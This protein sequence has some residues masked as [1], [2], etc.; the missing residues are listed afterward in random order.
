M[1]AYITDVS[2]FL[3]G[4]P[5]ANN[6]LDLYLGSVDRISARTR[7][8]ILAGNGIE[9]RHYAVE[10]ATGALTHTNAQLAAE[11]VGR[12]TERHEKVAEKIQ[13][14]CC[15]TSSPDQLMPGHAAMVQGELGIGPCEIVSTAGVCV[16]GITA[17]KY[18]AMS[19]A[20]GQTDNAV[21]TGSELASTFIRTDFF[22]AMGGGAKRL[23]QGENH[24]A[25][26]FEEQF[27]RWM[28]SDGAGAVLIKREPA[29]DR[30]SLRIDG[31]EILSHAHRLEACMY[32]GAVKQEDG[33]LK[34]WR[35]YARSGAAAKEGVFTI[36]QDA[37][38]LNREVTRAL[39]GQSLPSIIAKHGLKAEEICWFLPHYSSEY[40]RD[41]LAGQL[42][43]IDF[44]IPQER[45]FTNLATKGNTGSASFYIML[46]ELFSS[47]RLHKG[48]RILGF[49]PE[50]GRFSVAYVLLT[51]V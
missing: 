26:C 46:A 36:K 39:V 3:P 32:A 45:W 19:V 17:L 35:E 4:K 25:F 34:G 21:A 38:L 50:S 13:C 10:S 11:A 42:Q 1:Q 44:S 5:V 43:D 33:T 51:V 7:Q 30:L 28:L 29:A 37:R 48:D 24:P 23:A 6:E 49:I 20:L 16:T 27:L 47:G 12:L 9:S 14:L 2:E 22:E 41:A 8:I 31:I 40:F 15:G 18:G